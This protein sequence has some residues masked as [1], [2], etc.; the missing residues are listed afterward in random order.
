MPYLFIQSGAIWYVL[1]EQFDGGVRRLGAMHTKLL[2]N[3]FLDIRGAHFLSPASNPLKNWREFF[4]FLLTS[5]L[6]G[7]EV[8]SLI[9][10]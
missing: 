5:T 4:E 1:L 9:Q 3:S 2:N 7:I 10:T 6:S 8:Y